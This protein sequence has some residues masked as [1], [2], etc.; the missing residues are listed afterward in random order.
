[1]TDKARNSL[2]ALCDN[3]GP[4]LWLLLDEVAIE[5]YFGSG[6]TALGKAEAFAKEAGCAFIQNGN[7]VKLGRAYYVQW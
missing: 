5:R 1:M 4:N 3:L 2:M 6:E 7:T